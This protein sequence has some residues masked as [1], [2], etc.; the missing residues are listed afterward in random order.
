MIASANVCDSS[1]W[2]N[3]VCTAIQP[4]GATGPI[5]PFVEGAISAITLFIVIYALGRLVTAYTNRLTP[6]RSACSCR[7]GG[8]A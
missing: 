2:F 5:G 3:F 7:A 4:H 1:N 8:S 6:I